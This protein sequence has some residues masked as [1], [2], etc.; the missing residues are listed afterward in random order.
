MMRSKNGPKARRDAA[1]SLHRQPAQV[2][3]EDLDQHV[4][5]HEYRDGEAHHRQSH[6]E[7]IDPGAVFPGRDHA[8]RHRDQDGKDDGRDRDRD[9][10]LDALADHFQHRHVG[11]QGHAEIA[12]QE[13][14]DPGEELGV[15]RFVEAERGADA[16][17]LLGGRVVARQDRG[18][19]ARRQPQQQKHEQRHHAHHG[20]GGKHA[21]KQIS[22][23]HAHPSASSLRKQGPIG[24]GLSFERRYST[25]LAQQLTALVMGPCFRRD[26][27]W[28][29]RNAPEIHQCHSRILP[30]QGL[31]AACPI[32]RQAERFSPIDIAQMRDRCT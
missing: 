31:Q 28:S 20:N 4:A 1:K 21:A 14:A 11:N 13:L 3:R 8:E 19:I 27:G 5:D 10:R 16:F 2:D 23:H 30:P 24:R 32:A 12:M 7:A 26:D 29:L 17:K 15:E 22:E 9:R 25:T 18:G 6:H